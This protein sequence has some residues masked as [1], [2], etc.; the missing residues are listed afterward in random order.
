MLC[1]ASSV[2]AATATWQAR[3]GRPETTC[4]VV[5]AL[6]SPIQGSSDDGLLVTSSGV[7][8]GLDQAILSNPATDGARSLR[9]AADRWASHLTSRLTEHEKQLL[10]E[11]ADSG[12]LEIKVDAET[13]QFLDVKPRDGRT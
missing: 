10:R 13:G 12:A 8:V 9:D 3:S 4:D 6:S 11:Q 2:W 7:R 1:V 5:A